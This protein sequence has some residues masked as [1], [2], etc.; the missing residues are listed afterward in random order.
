MF[1]VPDRTVGI[2]AGSQVCLAELSPVARSVVLWAQA[3]R[4]WADILLFSRL[5]CHQ[6]SACCGHFSVPR[7]WA[8]NQT[9]TRHLQPLCSFSG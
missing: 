9:E 5:F 8:V 4:D 1:G 3:T 7:R 6:G 2:L